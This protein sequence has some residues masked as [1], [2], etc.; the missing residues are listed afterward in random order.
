M[1]R[2]IV[3]VL[4]TDLVRSTELF[5]RLS[6]EQAETVRR[7][8]FD[9]L[10]AVVDDSGGEMVKTLGDGVMAVFALASSAVECAVAAQRRFSVKETDVSLP[11][12]RAGIA[13]G[14]ATVEDGDY[15]GAP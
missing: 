15:H 8:H 3:S 4:F 14:E 5:G 10:R 13:A 12:L 11:G 6:A 2:R 1:E 9:A 7:G